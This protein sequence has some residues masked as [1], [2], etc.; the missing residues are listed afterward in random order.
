[1]TREEFVADHLTRCTAK[2]APKY[3]PK[4]KSPG[5]HTVAYSRRKCAKSLW[6]KLRQRAAEALAQVHDRR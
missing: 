4:K 1:M 3:D 5:Y 6:R 2:A